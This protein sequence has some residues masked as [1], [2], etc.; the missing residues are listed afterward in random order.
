MKHL[1][2]T[3]AARAT[4]DLVLNTAFT[5]AL[6]MLLPCMELSILQGCVE[7][8]ENVGQHI[9]QLPTW[10]YR[11]RNRK[12]SEATVILGWPCDHLDRPLCSV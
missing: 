3:A 8:E 7:N 2:E 1:E 10:E 11:E 5:G 4:S 6:E 9:V 12:P